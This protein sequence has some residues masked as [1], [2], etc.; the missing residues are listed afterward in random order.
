MRLLASFI[1]GAIFAIGLALSGMTQPD[2][3]I[4]FLDFFG[5]WKGELMFVMG[6]AV[7]TL[8]AIKKLI[9]GMRRPLFEERFR[10][11]TRNDVN[12]SLLGGAAL[13]GIG[14]GLVGLCPGPAIASLATLEPDILYFAAAMAVGMT[15]HTK[16][17]RHLE[18]G[19]QS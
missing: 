11:P 7:V 17:E 12:F 2:K 18:K 4:G 13:F 10:V 5:D 1:A 6:G 8:F 9:G 3:V 14:W 15:L 19:L 16:W